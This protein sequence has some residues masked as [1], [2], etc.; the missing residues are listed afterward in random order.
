MTSND[1][2]KDL[3]RSVKLCRVVRTLDETE[4]SNEI[5]DEYELQDD[6]FCA[7][8]DYISD[9]DIYYYQGKIT[10]DIMFE[11]GEGIVCTL[12]EICSQ[13][14]MREI[15]EEEFRVTPPMLAPDEYEM[16]A[17]TIICSAFEE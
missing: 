5:Y 4:T 15:M 16:V 10:F 1:E 11:N 9:V 3:L 13:S 14:K 12:D 7:W 6:N 8:T 17:F 2:F